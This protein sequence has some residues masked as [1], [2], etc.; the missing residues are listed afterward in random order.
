MTVIIANLALVL[1]AGWLFRR[2]GVV[3]EGAEKAFN[4]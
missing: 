1:A 2:F 3:Q 4:Q